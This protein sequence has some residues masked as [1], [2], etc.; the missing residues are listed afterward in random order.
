MKKKFNLRKE[1]ISK[2]KGQAKYIDD[3][4]LT[5]G[6]H[7]ATVRS[8]EVRGMLKK[9]HFSPKINWDEFV[10][11]T[12]Q[13]IPG[14]NYIS[15]I[16]MDW[17]VLVNEK[18][19]HKGEAIALIAHPD[20]AEVKRALNFIS[21]EIDPLPAVFNIDDSL[22]KKN[23]IWRDNNLFKEYTIEKG[24]PDPFWDDPNL[25]VF[26]QQ[27]STGAQEQ[28]YIENNG[29]IGEYSD[30]EGVTVRGSLQCPYY[31]HSALCP[32]FDLPEDKIRI[33]QA[34]T[35]GGFGG[36]EEFPSLLAA[37]AALLAMK[38]GK[39][40][41]LIYDRAEDMANSTKRHPSQSTHKM[42]VD[43]N[44]K[45][46]GWEIDFY[47]DGGAYFTL[48]SVV[49]S[50]GC[51]HAPGPYYCENT[52][53][54]AKAVATN[55]FPHG[56]FRGFGAPQSIF[57]T[58][59]FMDFVAKQLNIDPI[60]FRFKNMIKKGQTTATGQLIEESINYKKL[61]QKVLEASEFDKKT[62]KYARENKNSHLKRGFGIATFMHGAGFTG[63]GEAYLASVVGVQGT[64]DGKIEILASSVEMG[65]G[66]NT[67]FS[68]IAAEALGVSP[69]RIVIATPDTKYVPDSGPTVASR[70]SMVVGKLVQSACISLIK[71][72]QDENLIKNKFNQD[73]L[74]N[75]IKN[76]IKS[77]GDLKVFSKYKQPPNIHWDDE[78]YQ[79]S[80]Y[81]T[82]AWAVYLAEVEVNTL[83]YDTKVLNFYANQEIG[84]VLHPTMAAG[85]IEGGVAQAIG[86]AI[87]EKV[88]YQEGQMIN[89]QMTNY[90]MP[91][92]L[93]VPDIHVFFEQWNKDYGPGGAKGIGELPMDG[94]A[95]AII[96]AVENATG[97]K[98]NHI[99]ML[100]EDL[101][102]AM[103]N[104]HE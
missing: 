71:K 12:A 102:H 32:I 63:S 41:K 11:V 99:P 89:N 80:A 91:T 57:A 60:E 88:R 51:I 55:T 101:F 17:P 58:E 66:K 104:S 52:R 19:N 27:Y 79:G 67:I 25:Q 40:V 6:L 54:N 74:T 37:H 59:R 2:L 3:F 24:N 43:K 92:A 82:Y 47:L 64:E 85:Q 9:I 22:E 83:T 65:Q 75:A 87:Y 46:K 29:M 13:D 10:I 100:P 28:L 96:N 5:D 86:Y 90:I 1:G 7:G 21:F 78:K 62:K 48:S 50:R 103:E 73:E 84:N 76:Y 49:L 26:S 56:A 44:G 81:A 94:P 35:G 77:R 34:E 72:L 33:I 20:K 69:D 39:P 4:K 45:I 23:I 53:V 38:S 98:I 93:D 15:M 31:V 14:K 18:I 95:P 42:A 16:E 36:K 97:V 8:P 30:E 70:T 68:T 61:V